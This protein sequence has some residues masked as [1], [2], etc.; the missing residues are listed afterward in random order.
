MRERYVSAVAFL[1][2]TG[3]IVLSA[4]AFMTGMAPLF[5]FIYFYALLSFSYLFYRYT[6][7]IINYPLHHS[8]HKNVFYEP[9]VSIILPCYNEGQES[10]K[11]CIVNA[12]RANYPNKEV[13]VVDDGSLS[14][15]VW[16]TITEMKKRY[17]FQAYRFTKN[18]GKRHA[19]AFGF[20][21]A[22]GDI[23]ITM[24]SD[25]IIPSG[26]SIKDLVKP[27][28]NKKIG[29]V[30]GCVLVKNVN[31]SLLTRI[32]DARYW[33][34][35]Y[36]EKSSQNPYNAVTCAS[37]PFSAYRKEY[38][39]RFLDEWENQIFL[40]QKCTYGDDRGLTTFILKE[41]YE[42]KFVRDAVSYTDVPAT[43]QKFL[44]QQIRWKKSFIRENWYLA[45][46]IHKKNIFMKI[47]FI[48]FWIV[49]LAGFIAKATSI[50]FVIFGV[51]PFAHYIVMILFVA[52]LHYIYAFIR[53]PGK[54]G[55]FGILYGLFNEF[56]VSWLFF[57]SLLK[58][59]DTKWGTR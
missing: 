54:R 5:S 24:D 23:V 8:K 44:K 17:D 3:F 50:G 16:Q 27:F 45:H 51:L 41:G 6:F 47:E 48:L 1:I 52:F 37:G 34:A 13:I 35:F 18:L 56:L 4:V 26:K 29:A 53:S 59:R 38:V 12:C 22:K 14:P 32:Q 39:L 7:A 15:R 30:S 21:K 11:N 33:L 43:L 46:F 9:S 40:G 55:Y 28:V 42:T 20:R 36:I 2:F 10:L 58:L 25:S 57:Y 49:F 19:M 31:K